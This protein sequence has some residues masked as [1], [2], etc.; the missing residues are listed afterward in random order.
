M[1]SRSWIQLPHPPFAIIEPR[2]R[3]TRE[4]A[5][6]RTW[7]PR[8][9]YAL[10]IRRGGPTVE[11]PP[12]PPDQRRSG[13]YRIPFASAWRNEERSWSSRDSTSA[14]PSL[15]TIGTSFP[16]VPQ[17]GVT[18]R[19]GTATSIPET[20][21]N[22]CRLD[23]A[24]RLPSVKTD[25]SEPPHRAHVAT[26]SMDQPS[27]SS[28]VAV[29]DFG[30]VVTGTARGVV[31]PVSPEEVGEV[32]R[33][34][35]ASGSKVTLRGVG[36]SAGGQAVP[37]DSVVLD[38]SSLNGI[39][40]VDSSGMT[41]R[42]QAG[43]TL[44]QIVD[45]TLPHGLLP[46]VLTNLLDLTVG[47]ILGVAGGI[48]PAS[49]RHGS[50]SATVTE[51]DVVTGD[52]V[53]H[54]CSRSLGPELFGSVIGGLGLAGAIVSAEL[55]L[56]RIKQR[57]RTFY[58]LYDD[59]DRW[60]DDQRLLADA[61]VDA[62]E[63]FCSAAPQGLRG[64][65]GQRTGFVHWLYPLQVAIEYEDREPELPGAIHPYRVLGVEDDDIRFFPTRHDPRFE[66][67]RRIGA[68]ERP[69]PYVSAFID[70][71]EL[72]EVLPAVL[73]SL[74]TFLGDGH[75]GVFL[76]DRTGSPPLLALPISD[77]VAFFSVIYPQ[78]LPPFLDAAL[79]AFARVGELLADAGGKRYVADWLGDPDEASWQAHFGAEYGR[80]I[81]AR[82]AYDPHG[83][84][85][86]ALVPRI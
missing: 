33:E 43:A 29:E 64:V 36:H 40:P 14:P 7:L 54:R 69:H 24:E 56:R 31:R 26:S 34:A 15:L 75:R 86:S 38:M 57:V 44:R 48:G 13:S 11:H 61:N 2:T 84:F 83:I 58:L 60:L 77:D 27:V 76:V 80:W 35:I 51:L 21:H 17:R 41:I 39:G 16:F 25:G 8:P 74:P 55:A 66:L 72:N 4:C 78:V 50:L 73:N 53:I 52:G 81:Q 67:M 18:A 1:I 85:C 5:T 28:T 71:Q 49:L 23:L 30:H 79:E 32:I 37:A 3:L 10:R 9:R 65:G 82:A 12:R 59:L 68:W 63:G 6:H 42:C 70:R 22:L 20:T 19:F 62:M 46:R 47:G 45:A